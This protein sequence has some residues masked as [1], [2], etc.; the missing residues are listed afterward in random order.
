MNNTLIQTLSDQEIKFEFGDKRLDRRG[1]RIIE[2]L[3]K[4]SGKSLPQVFCNGSDLRGAYRFFSNSQITPKSILTPH[5]TETIC[6]CETQNTVL[7]IQDSSDLDFDYMECLE[8]FNSLH[9]N[10]EKG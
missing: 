5:R 4:N 6:R 10:V 8:G 3:A 9:T 2:T 7:V 1:K